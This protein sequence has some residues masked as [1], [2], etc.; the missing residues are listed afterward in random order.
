MQGAIR[1]VDNLQQC[2][3]A[4][5]EAGQLKD[6]TVQYLQQNPGN[7]NLNAAA[8]VAVVISSNWPCPK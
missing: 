3:P 7:R 2:I 5:V 1:N 6:A 8:L 4:T